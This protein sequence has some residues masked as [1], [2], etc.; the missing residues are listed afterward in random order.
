[1]LNE[2]TVMTIKRHDATA[3]LKIQ[4]M[5]DPGQ[6]QRLK[7]AVGTLDGVLRVDTNYIL[8]SVTIKYDAD[9]ITL[10]QI[11]KKLGQNIR[12]SV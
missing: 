1:M 11:K 2:P 7:R 10:A 3:I 4:G 12:A 8:D 5:N 9:K 6:A